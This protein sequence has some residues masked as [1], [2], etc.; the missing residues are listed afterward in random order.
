MD[1]TA[2]VLIFL[3]TL[4]LFI[5]IAAAVKAFSKGPIFEKAASRNPRGASFNILRFQTLGPER[6]IPVVGAILR[7][8]GL[9]ELPILLNVLRGDT[10]LIGPCPSGFVPA[11]GNNS[12]PADGKY[13]ILCARLCGSNCESV[14]PEICRGVSRQYQQ[15]HSTRL[16][17]QI[18]GTFFKDIFCFRNH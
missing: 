12:L 11:Q 3:L 18:L 15:Q 14:D 10:N 8:Y 7:Q 1:Y 13:G 9:D 16:D 2:A 6:P 4:P 5:L 17:L